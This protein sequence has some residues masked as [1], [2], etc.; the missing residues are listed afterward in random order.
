MTLNKKNIRHEWVK[1]NFGDIMQKLPIAIYLIAAMVMF[2][3]S[4]KTNDWKF[5]ILLI[6]HL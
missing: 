5:T 2:I 4:D 3:L 1:F 6:S